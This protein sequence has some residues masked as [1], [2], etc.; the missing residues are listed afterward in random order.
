MTTMDKKVT[1][2]LPQEMWDGMKADMNEG[3]YSESEY[4]RN[5]VRERLKQKAGAVA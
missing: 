5:L 2:Y 4:I 3:H 1:A